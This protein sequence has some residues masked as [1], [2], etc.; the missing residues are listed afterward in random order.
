[1]GITR[2][3]NQTATLWKRSGQDV[4]GNQTFSSP[5][6]ISVRWEDRQELFAGAEGETNRAETVV[7]SLDS[8]DELDY[9][10]LGSSSASDPIDSATDA[11]EIRQVL[12]SP[13][14]RDTQTLYKFML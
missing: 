12:K 13:N 1:M 14:L 8:A 6:E 3:L 2:N 7:Y 4:Y 10:T 9:I 5:V 11:R